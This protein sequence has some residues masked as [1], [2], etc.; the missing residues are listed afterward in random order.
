M[1]M[2]N[3]KEILFVLLIQ[4]LWLLVYPFSLIIGHFIMQ[5][6]LKKFI[7]LLYCPIVI[8]PQVIAES[9]NNDLSKRIKKIYYSRHC[10]ICLEIPSEMS[11]LTPCGHCVA[12]ND[13]KLYIET[14]PYCRNGINTQIKTNLLLT[15]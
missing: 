8:K 9:K 12:C 5:Y 7:K 14:C 3:Q 4:L 13:C 10:L 6:L 1:I 11:I 15:N 2:H